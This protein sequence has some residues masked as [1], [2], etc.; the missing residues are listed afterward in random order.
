LDILASNE[1]EVAINILSGSSNLNRSQLHKRFLAFKAGIGGPEA[2]GA[3]SRSRRKTASPIK[4][5]G[6]LGSNPN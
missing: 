5:K 2:A 3:G 4:E 6:Q 1:L